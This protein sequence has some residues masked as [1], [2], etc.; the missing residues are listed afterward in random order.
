[1]SAFI[2]LL[3]RPKLWGITLEALWLSGWYRYNL[4]HRP[5][6]K[7]S[8]KIGEYRYETSEEP[9]T[10][11]KVM[12]TCARVRHVVL[13]VCKRTPWE[14]LCLVQALTAKKL[15]NQKGIKC[16]LYMGVR[17]GD[18]GE[19]LAHAWLRCGNKL[20]TGENGYL[21][22]TVTGTYGDR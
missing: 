22:Y 9:I 12:A 21:A 17:N 20:I 3:R 18:N 16:T 1:M 8:P 11:A 15:L 5:F 14:S 13:G 4:I 2:K 19:M 6:A 7:I 10:D